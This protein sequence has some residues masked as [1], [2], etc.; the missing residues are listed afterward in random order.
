M[1]IRSDVDGEG[2]HERLWTDFW[3]T[4]GVIAAVTLLVFVR[5]IMLGEYI[6]NRQ[7]HAS[8]IGCATEYSTDMLPHKICQVL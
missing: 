5:R 3:V 2:K 8:I 4:G 7:R 1:I 6:K